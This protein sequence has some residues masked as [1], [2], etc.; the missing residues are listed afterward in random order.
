MKD[1]AEPSGTQPLSV[2]W[3]YTAREGAVVGPIFEEQLVQA[4]REGHVEPDTLVWQEAFEKWEIACNV[5]DLSA[6]L[7]WLPKRLD[8]A[9]MLE[10]RILDPGV[11][12]FV[13]TPAAPET[14]SVS[15]SRRWAA[16]EAPDAAA[17]ELCDALTEEEAAEPIINLSLAREIVDRASCLPP[18][19]SIPP[20]SISW[21]PPQLQHEQNRSMFAR[22]MVAIAVGLLAI[23]SGMVLVRLTQARRANTVIQESSSPAQ[24]SPLLNG[25][26]PIGAAAFESA[27]VANGASPAEPTRQEPV[28]VAQAEP[29][30][31][32]R[33]EGPLEPHLVQRLLDKN[34]LVFE[35]QCW[36]PARL[37]S[38]RV[39]DHPSVQLEVIIDRKGRVYNVKYGRDPQGYYGV[40][41]CI[42]GRIRG[43]KFP[44]HDRASSVVLRLDRHPT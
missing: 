24:S 44:A 40:S 10:A 3:Y 41:P 43:W 2:E 30:S 11:D 33:I 12:G 22:P 27:V 39:D 36:K 21:T 1:E 26:R 23:A 19:R 34:D 15:D 8:P 9:A 38:T 20:A 18:E 25:V 29:A 31:G 7:G 5:P 6:V 17:E 28:L 37:F 13:E 35:V 42:G 14:E 4:I 32:V 16:I